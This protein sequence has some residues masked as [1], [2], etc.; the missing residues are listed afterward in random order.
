MKR[1][2]FAALGLLLSVLAAQAQVRVDSVYFDGRASFRADMAPGGHFDAGLVGEALNLNMWGKLSPSVSYRLRQRFN[3]PLYD[4]DN[5]LNATDWLLLSWKATPRWTFNAG[6][7]PTLIGGYEWDYAPIDLHFWSNFDDTIGQYYALGGAA[8]YQIA[9]GQQLQMQVTRSLLSR[10]YSNVWSSA[11]G[12]TGSF[13]PWWK[14][15]WAFTF[16][17]DPY[18]HR[19]SYT[20]LGNRFEAGPVALEVDFMYRRALLPIGGMGPDVTVV[21][22]LW[23]TL[24]KFHLFTKG[25]FD[26]ND[27]ANVDCNGVPYDLTVAPGTRYY[28]AG[29]GVEYFPL[30]NRHIRLHATGWWDNR[31]NLFTFNAGVSFR[32]YV[33]H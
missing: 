7:M 9:D 32:L 6:K 12:W 15:I 33:V 24:G 2:L 25:G 27:A 13:A 19:M 21:G 16:M 22:H 29:G 30:G 18:R 20:T 11:L 10:G 5:P 28:Y 3:I 4:K 26:Y 14:T 23:W 1:A 17:D 8:I 31:A